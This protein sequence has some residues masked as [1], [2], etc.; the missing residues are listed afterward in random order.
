VADAMHT[1]TKVSG[2]SGGTAPKK[3]TDGYAS[4]RVSEQVIGTKVGK[5]N[6]KG[7]SGP[8]VAQRSSQG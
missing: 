3:K 5:V 4:G 8:P 1:H 2:G 7:Y 6:G